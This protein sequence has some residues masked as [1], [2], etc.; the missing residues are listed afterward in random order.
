MA[1]ID[2][3]APSVV[4]LCMLVL[5]ILVSFVTVV[6]TIRVVRFKRNILK[7]QAANRKREAERRRRRVTE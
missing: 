1:A 4:I 7:F 6:H 5:S 2:W 3:S